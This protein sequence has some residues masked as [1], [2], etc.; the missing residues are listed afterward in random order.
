MRILKVVVIM[1]F[2]LVSI[3]SLIAASATQQ[4]AR[5]QAQPANADQYVGSEACREC[6]SD[7]AARF[8]VTAH[9]QT[10]GKE[11]SVDRH[12]CEACHGPAK[13]HLQ[14]YQTAQQLLKEGKDDEAAKLYAD[15]AQAAA[16]RMLKFDN[17]SSKAVSAVCLKCHESEVG[18]A[19]ER[20]NF[21][22]SEHLRHGVSCLDCHSVHS[23]KESEYLLRASQPESCYQC[24]GDQKASFARPFH[25]KV[26]EGGMKCSDC[27]N[28]HGGFANKQLRTRADGGVICVK[29]HTDKAGPFV[30]E[31]APVKIEG[32]QVCHNPH[33]STN[34]RLLKRNAV[35]F[36]C[37]EC[38]SNLG[39]PSIAT[40]RGPATP[41][42]HDLSTT[43]YQN[44]TTCHVM[45]H[46]SNASSV[47]FR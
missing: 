28:Q 5:L 39:A 25:H 40:G 26:P 10:L 14:Y 41:S 30:Y 4:Q 1:S 22:R 2:S 6:H 8:G 12:G 44:C 15:E 42:F 45:I 46:G 34:S 35:R 37:L 33:G 36:L 31:H 19:G 18:R 17:L 21:R 38:H 3:T 7:L 27:H 23:P 13:K 24:H 16:A 11:T 9:R 20:L 47:F 43:T 29:C 32:C